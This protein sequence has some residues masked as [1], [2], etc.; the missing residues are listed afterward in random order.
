M[1]TENDTHFKRIFEKK[2]SLWKGWAE[3]IEKSLEKS[4][5]H[6]QNMLLEC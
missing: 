5:F 6:N 2:S 1:S 4:I 3:K